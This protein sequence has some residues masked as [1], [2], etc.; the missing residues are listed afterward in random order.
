MSRAM[1]RVV[2]LLAVAMLSVAGCSLM[3]PQPEL[4]IPTPPVATP[5]LFIPDA[6]GEIT[7]DPV[8]DVV[9]NIDPRCV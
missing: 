2:I 7:T 3:Q 8:S 6:Q 9:P 4:I 5:A 1:I